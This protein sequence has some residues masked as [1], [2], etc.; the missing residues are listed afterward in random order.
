M[1]FFF[2]AED[3]IRDKLVTG[4]Q[5]CALPIFLL[6]RAVAYGVVHEH[7]EPQ[8]ERL[9]PADHDLPVNETVVD[10]VERNGHAAGVRIALPP[11]SAARCAASAGDRSRWNTK[12]S[13]IARLTPVTTA[14]SVL[15]RASRIEV[16]R[17]EPPGRS[18]NS[19]AGRPPIA[20]ASRV[21]SAPE[22]QPSL[23]TGTSASPIPVMAATAAR[24][25]WATAACDTITPRSGSLIVLLEVLLELALLGHAADEALVEGL[26]RVHAAVAQQMVH[27]HHLADHREVLARVERHGDERQRHFQHLRLLAL[28]AGAVVLAPRV[29]VLELDDDLDALLLPHRPDPEQR[30][31][32]DQPH[33][34]DLHVMSRQLVPAPDQHVVA[35]A[36]DVHDVV[37]D[38]A[39]APLHQIEHALALAHPRAPEEEQPHSE[40]VGGPAVH[41]GAGGERVVEE[42]LQPGVQLRGLELGADH[43]DALRPG[44]LEQL[45]RR[46]LALRDHHAGD[47]ETEQGLERPAARRPVERG[48]VGD[49]K[50]TRLNS[51]H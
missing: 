8:V 17:Q 38:Q 42:R 31:D 35:A 22:S 12:S 4:V 43:R 15:P 1:F 21:V 33:A 24:S 40:H 51:S 46:L 44:Q 19:T 37:R 16:V 26:G 34:A 5:T 25:A 49:R 50:S 2:Q 36:V 39:G 9:A 41:R 32:V 47:V 6:P 13:S 20:S 11:A 18:T 27:G 30:L 3:G 28:D 7:D 14:T 48:E 23:L 10:T 29:P 45:G